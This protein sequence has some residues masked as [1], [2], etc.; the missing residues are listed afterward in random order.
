MTA[1][2]RRVTDAQVAVRLQP[3][4]ARDEIVGLRDGVLV[5][6]VSAPP[7]DGR[8]NK[9][10]CKLI[11]RRAGVAPTRVSVVRGERS[12]DKLVLVAGIEPAAL[13]AALG[14]ESG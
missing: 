14:M 8:A 13:T 12:R 5:V 10:L 2:I 1:M 11:A 4:A 6:R 3:R 7:V 9:A